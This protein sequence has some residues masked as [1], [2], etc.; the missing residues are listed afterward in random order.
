MKFIGLDHFIYELLE[1]E[2]LTVYIYMKKAY[3]IEDKIFQIIWGSV[4][5]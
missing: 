5:S 2:Q 4:K 1:V 3:Y